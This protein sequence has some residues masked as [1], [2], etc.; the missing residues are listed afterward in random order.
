LPARG[1]RTPQIGILKPVSVGAGPA[2]G[3]VAQMRFQP[4]PVIGLQFAVHM[5][6][7]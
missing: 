5:S 2:T 1:K 7:Q 3:T 4:G 6:V